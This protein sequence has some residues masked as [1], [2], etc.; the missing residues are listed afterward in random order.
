VFARLSAA[1]HE[2]LG[3]VPGPAGLSLRDE[4]LDL[5]VR[6]TAP[7]PTSPLPRPATLTVGRDAD[8]LAVCE[9]LDRARVVTLLGPGGVGKTRLAAEVALRRERAGIDTRFVDLTRA[10]RPDEVLDL[11]VRELGLHE[12]GRAVDDRQARHALAGR[13]MLVVLDNFEHVIDRVDVVSR[14]VSWSPGLQALVTSRVRLH[15]AGE[16]IHDVAPLPVEQ[17][18]GRGRGED[19]VALFSQVARAADPAFDVGRHLSDVVEICRC[20]DGLPLAIELAAGHV[21]TLTPALLRSRL[22]VRLHSGTGAARDLPA[23]HLTM[24]ATIE[25]SLQLLRREE[26]TLFA[27]L[28][29]FGSDVPL[30]AVEQVCG[31]GLADVVGDLTGLVDSSL[32]RRRADAANGEPRFGMLSLLRE[33]ARALLSEQPD[34]TARRHALYH[35]DLLDRLEEQ[36]WT[37]VGRWVDR[38]SDLHHELRSAHAWAVSNAEPEVAA[39]ITASLT[40]F[41]HRNGY[42]DEARSWVTHALDHEEEVTELTLARVRVAAG[43][44]SWTQD[45]LASRDPFTAAAEVFRSLGEERLLSYALALASGTHISIP[46]E[47]DAALA[48]C[49]EAIAIARRRGEGHLLAIALNEK[50]ELARVHGDDDL[51]RRVYDE[52][53]AAAQRAGDEAHVSVFLAN[54]SY[55]ACHRGDL[56]EGLRLCREALQICWRLGRRLMTA[57]VLSQLAGPEA[58]LGR[59]ERGATL[60]GAADAALEHLGGGRFPGDLEE[61]ERVVAQLHGALGADG[62]AQ[63]HAHGQQLS[64][65][66]AVSLALSERVPGLAS[67]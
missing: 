24:P 19:A 7:P 63:W 23:R 21:R 27:R 60:V 37:Q 22:T 67:A 14:L 32:V 57:W 33:H 66:D 64:L 38:V 44:L 51:A 40:L 5:E 61:H 29:V 6:A 25:W 43:V 59:P 39:R 11:V 12:D 41:W 31:N 48:Q 52:G 30:D 8:I 34:D 62:Y 35:A 49:D 16:H 10:D 45:P 15:V 28:G 42:H 9:L 3:L 17:P 53:C 47:Y 4:A 18:D 58:G 26:R 13:P 65:S 2:E 50:G 56:E 55:L 36:R 46:E 1:L 54:L 20:L